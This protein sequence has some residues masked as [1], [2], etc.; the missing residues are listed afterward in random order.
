MSEQEEILKELKAKF[1]ALC[2]EQEQLPRDGF[3]KVFEV[4]DS[5]EEDF[6]PQ[7]SYTENEDNIN[8]ALKLTGHST[9]EAFCKAFKRNNQIMIE[10][11]KIQ[12]KSLE[13]F[14]KQQCEKMQ[15][16]PHNLNEW[17]FVPI[18]I[19]A[20]KEI[21]NEVI[22]PIMEA[23]AQGGKG[24]FANITNIPLED[25]NEDDFTMIDV[26]NCTATFTKYLDELKNFGIIGR[27]KTDA[28]FSLDFKEY[29][30]QSL[31]Y[32]ATYIKEHT[33]TP[34]QTKNE[35]TETI[36]EFDQIPIWGLFFQI[37]I[38]QGLCRWMESVNIN[39]GDKGFDE[40]QSCYNWLIEALGEKLVSFCFVP[41][42]DKDKELLKPLCNYLNSTEIGKAVQYE[43]FCQ[44]TENN[45]E[46]TRKPQPKQKLDTETFLTV[47]LR[48]ERALKYF[49][50]AIEAN[51]ITKTDTGY[52]I[53]SA[54][55]TKA[56]LAYFL[57]LVFCRDNT[58]KDNGNDFPETDLNT[59]FGESRLGKARGQYASNK[60]GKPKGYKIIDKIF[61]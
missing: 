29:L 33:N 38:L 10:G 32:L 35:I 3:A 26:Y 12:A 15:E 14:A 13:I 19:V 17:Q 11:K 24:L 5:L 48:T 27:G 2:D 37:L 42:G 44:D 22:T 58:G 16:K 8:K 61:E 25:V 36:K 45:E 9:D 47:E 51:I 18:K 7:H 34:A 46:T 6:T 53:G 40:A 50:K 30:F 57:E 4:L 59:L 56:L 60:S 1:D 21:M 54:I 43:L 31:K 49:P 20:P 41:Y 39:E 23:D 52:S 28:F 55:K